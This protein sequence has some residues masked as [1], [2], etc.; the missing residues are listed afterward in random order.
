[1]LRYGTAGYGSI[2]VEEISR[3][4]IVITGLEVVERGLSILGLTA[5]SFYSH[6]IPTRNL[7]ISCGYF[8]TDYLAK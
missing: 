6:S 5:G 3:L 1:M 4:R 8:D 2:I 7:R